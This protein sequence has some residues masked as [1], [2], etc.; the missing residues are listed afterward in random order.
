VQLVPDASRATGYRIEDARSGDEGW[1]EDYLAV[2]YPTNKGITEI[3]ARGDWMGDGYLQSLRK[4]DGTKGPFKV[5]FG[6]RQPDNALL[7]P[8]A[9][10]SG[11][12]G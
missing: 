8:L 7:V 3:F 1:Q 11:D 9:A 2:A 10:L 6:G 5:R 12:E 4:L